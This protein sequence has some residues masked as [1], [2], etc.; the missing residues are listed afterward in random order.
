MSVQPRALGQRAGTKRESAASREAAV[1]GVLRQRRAAI[2]AET[3]EQLLAGEDPDLIV[4]PALYKALAAERIVDAALGFVVTEG[5][6]SM[7]L[8]FMKGF[9]RE[10]MQRCL[11]LDFGQ[12]I[13]GTVARTQRPM[14]V[15]DIQRSLDPLADLVRSAGINA[16]ACEP[17]IAGGRLLG[18]LSFASRSRRSFDGDDLTFFKAVARHVATARNRGRRESAA[19]R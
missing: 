12:A 18:T 3:A 4:L 10:V 9:P 1:R 17:L 15:T 16:Y 7:N 2:L 8:G 5:A 19:K 14:H 6:E 13:C 11:T